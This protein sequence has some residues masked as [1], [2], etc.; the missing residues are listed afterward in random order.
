MRVAPYPN[1]LCFFLVGEHG[2]HANDLLK[3]EFKSETGSRHLTVQ[4]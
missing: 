2:Q 3:F 4:F 1:S